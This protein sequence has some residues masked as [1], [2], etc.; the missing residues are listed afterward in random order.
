MLVLERAGICSPPVRG[1]MSAF[2]AIEG[3]RCWFWT[4]RD[5]TPPVRGSMSVFFPVLGLYPF[6]VGG[7]Q[8][9]AGSGEGGSVPFGRLGG[10]GVGFGTLRDLA[11]TGSGVDA[12][13][14]PG[15]GDVPDRC[16][17]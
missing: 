5:L 16:R 1:P 10:P 14:F 17:W 2:W 12:Y 7:N 11:T 3:S 8:K 13:F 15:F 4:H 6:G 9:R